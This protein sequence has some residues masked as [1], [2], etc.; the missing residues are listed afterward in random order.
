[1]KR[2][3]SP[4][5]IEKRCQLMIV[6]GA[7]VMLS[8]GPAG[9]KV[10]LP[11]TTVGP[12]GFEKAENGEKVTETAAAIRVRSSGVTALRPTLM[13]GSPENFSSGLW[14]SPASGW[15]ILARESSTKSR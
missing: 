14:E 15:R 13:V 3:T 7:L 10:A 6:L 11:W 12:V 9:T 8:T 4:A 5:A 2:V 1:M